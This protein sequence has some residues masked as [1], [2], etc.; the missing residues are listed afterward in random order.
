MPS[1]LGQPQTMAACI[2][3]RSCC[4]GKRMQ[5]AL[6]VQLPL[7]EA[8]LQPDLQ[9]LLED[10]LN[11]RLRGA[12]GRVG[13]LGGGGRLVQLRLLQRAQDYVAHLRVRR[14]RTQPSQP[15]QDTRAPY[16]AA[17]T[18]QCP[19]TAQPYDLLLCPVHAGHSKAARHAAARCMPDSLVLTR[20]DT[21]PPALAESAASTAGKWRRAPGWACGGAG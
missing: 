20:P 10:A 17:C 2:G 8:N 12:S 11:G 16:G 6:G 9:A 14:A 1:R 13:S 18:T 3:E 21:L 19:H 5:R 4:S 7:M 15:R